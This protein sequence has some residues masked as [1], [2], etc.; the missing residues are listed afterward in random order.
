M[1][2]I[3]E[4]LFVKGAIGIR[5]NH[6]KSFYFYEVTRYPKSLAEWDWFRPLDIPNSRKEQIYLRM[7]RNEEDYLRNNTR[8]FKC[9]EPNIVPTTNL[10]QYLE[11]SI[12]LSKDNLIA[13][14]KTTLRVSAVKTKP[15]TETESQ[16]VQFL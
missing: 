9:T 3:E 5:W 13:V 8:F 10:V 4:V 15:L 6:N 2:I 14:P 11:T 16:R 12:E 7:T 1:Y